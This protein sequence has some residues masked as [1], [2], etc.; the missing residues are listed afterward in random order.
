MLTRERAQ[1]LARELVLDAVVGSRADVEKIGPRS[2]R[3]SWDGTATTWRPCRQRS[4]TSWPIGW[5]WSRRCDRGEE[6]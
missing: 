6:G 5:P 1:D 4:S 2:W 3:R